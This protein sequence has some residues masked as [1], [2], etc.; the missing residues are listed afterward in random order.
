MRRIV[1]AALLMLTAGCTTAVDGTPTA[2]PKPLPGDQIVLQVA[3]APG[4]APEVMYLTMGP[5]LTVYGD[6]R[7]VDTG[8]NKAAIPEYH[9]GKA[10][11]ATIATLAAEVR[12]SGLLEDEAAFGS[13]LVTDLGTTIVHLHDAAGELELQVYGLEMDAGLP[14]SQVRKRDALRELIDDWWTLTTLSPADP[15]RVQVMSTSYPQGAQGTTAWP[16]P[17]PDS[18]MAPIDSYADRCGVLEG[19][20]AAAVH[21]AAVGN[22]DQAWLV[23]GQSQ[24]LGV[25]PLVPGEKGC[26]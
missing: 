2:P 23:D 3:Y 10:D 14:L 18:F 19:A 26:T 20:T 5:A 17:P 6:G 12:S 22:P 9:V 8:R 7:V 4:Y 11:P 24:V 21:E 16:G 13:L 15:E 25:R 1:G